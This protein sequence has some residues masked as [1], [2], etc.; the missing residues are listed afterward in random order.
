MTR[1]PARAGWL[2]DERGGTRRPATFV[3]TQVTGRNRTL[4]RT[5]SQRIPAK[6]HVLSAEGV[7]SKD[8]LERSWAPRS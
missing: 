5:K 6:V 7:E 4:L 1:D 3:P 8:D 2:M